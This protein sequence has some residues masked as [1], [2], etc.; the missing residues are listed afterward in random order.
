M[1]TLNIEILPLAQEVK[2]TEDDLIVALVD[3]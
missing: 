1:S 3:G 2:F